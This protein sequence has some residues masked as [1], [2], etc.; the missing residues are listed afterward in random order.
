M[1]KTEED[2]KEEER[3]GEEKGKREKS[4]TVLMGQSYGIACLNSLE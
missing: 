1:G 2:E 3:D 4:R